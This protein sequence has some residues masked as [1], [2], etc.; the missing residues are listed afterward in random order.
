MV[1]GAVQLRLVSVDGP[2]PRAGHSSVGH[3]EGQVGGQLSQGLCVSSL[4]ATAGKCGLGI[5]ETIEMYNSILSTVYQKLPDWIYM[6]ELAMEV[7]K[8]RTF[9]D[10]RTT[11]RYSDPDYKITFHF[12]LGFL[13]I[14]DNTV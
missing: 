6:V 4:L 10:S 5:L 12:I 13:Q 14:L 11:S 1:G 7:D 2:L 3:N 9:K 8:F